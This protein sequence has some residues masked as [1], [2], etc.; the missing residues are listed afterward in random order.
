M[1]ARATLLLLA[2]AF[3]AAAGA[4]TPKAPPLAERCVSKRERPRAVEFRASDGVR[5]RGVLLGAGAT[6]VVLGHQ[7]GGSLCDWLPFGRVLARNGYRALAIDFRGYPSSGKGRASASLSYDR[8]FLAAAKLLRARGIKHVVFFGASMGGT[9]ALVGGS[10]L[11]TVAGVASFS[12]P[13]AFGSLYGTKAVATLRSP[14]LFLAGDSDSYFP[15]DARALYE[16]SVSSRKQLEIR[17]SRA[18]GSRLLEGTD[19]PAT[20][21]IVLEFLSKLDA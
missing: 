14:T 20:R 3:S 18:H 16:A 19:G 6:G 2:F 9:A 13:T 1:R 21:A 15:D 8:D 7:S 5:I 11:P 4:A 17:P 10:K 12:G